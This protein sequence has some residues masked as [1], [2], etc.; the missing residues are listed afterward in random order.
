MRYKMNKFTHPLK[1]TALGAVI[2]L[3]SACSSTKQDVYK[4]PLAGNCEQTALALDSNAQATGSEAQFL[5]S[6][7]TLYQCILE[8][9]FVDISGDNQRLMQLHALSVINFIKGGDIT[10]A[11]DAFSSFS[12]N[13]PNQD[14]LFADYTSFVDTITV[15]FEPNL[16]VKGGLAQL[17]VN[18]AL[19]KE[20]KRQAYWAMN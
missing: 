15:L 13:Y 17:N 3:S 11:K 14:L 16:A 4:S 5:S 8:V 20:L 18:N 7:N 12:Q 9:S 10:K 19:R 6:A 2:I 1:L